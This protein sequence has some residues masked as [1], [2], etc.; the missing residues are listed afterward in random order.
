MEACTNLNNA[1]AGQYVK[2]GTTRDGVRRVERIAKVWKNGRIDLGGHGNVF[3]PETDGGR[4]YPVG[5]SGRWSTWSSV[6]YPFAEGETVE[7]VQEALA[8]EAAAR[9][10]AQAKEDA[11]AEDETER[12]IAAARIKHSAGRDIE[13]SGVARWTDRRGNGRTTLYFAKPDSMYGKPGW[14]VQIADFENG[15]FSS[16]FATSLVSAEDAV[17]RW[18]AAW[19]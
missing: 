7:G 2:A 11:A 8:R 16:S 10:E 12:K 18:I 13:G 14:R 3:R 15:S 1:V 19:S 4:A 17:D 5:R 9:A 6:I